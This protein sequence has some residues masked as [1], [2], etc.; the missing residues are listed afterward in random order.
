MALQQ[1]PELLAPQ[2][3]E[4]G[5]VQDAYLAACAEELARRDNL[6]LPAWTESDDRKLRRPGLRHRSPRSE[7]Y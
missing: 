1:S 7:R 2:F 4:L 5:R 3:G 6:P